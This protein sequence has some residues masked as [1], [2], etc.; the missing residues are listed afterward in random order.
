M[1]QE[2][3]YLRTYDALRH[4][5]PS[6]GVVMDAPESDLEHLLRDAGLAPTKARQIQAILKEV[7]AR[8]GSLDLSRLRR[9]CDDEVEAYLTSLP[10]V[11]RK[12]ARCV[13]LYALDRKTCPVDTHVWRVMQ[14][15]GVA[16]AKAWSERNARDLEELIPRALRASLHVTLVAHGRAVCRARRPLCKECPLVALCPSADRRSGR[17]DRA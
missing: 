16:P 6:W 4:E 3:K 2:V 14:R 12:T 11:A 5:M 9:L 10:G 1:T 8:E 17:G 7:S 15:L 13:M